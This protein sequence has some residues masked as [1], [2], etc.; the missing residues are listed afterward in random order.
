MHR[1]EKKVIIFAIHG[2]LV[3]DRVQLITFSFRAN[4]SS[5]KYSKLSQ[6]LSKILSD[7]QTKEDIKEETKE[8]IFR[9]NYIKKE[10]TLPIDSVEAPIT[11]IFKDRI[12]N[13]RFA[14]EGGL[15]LA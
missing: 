8:E 10:W 4:D 9:Y 7:N 14:S 3:Q 13:T 11:I 12:I 15:D 2:D 6:I 5:E 1:T